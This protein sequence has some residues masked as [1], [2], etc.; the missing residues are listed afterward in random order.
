MPRIARVAIWATAFLAAAGAGAYIAAHSNPFPPG[1]EDPG[2]R[3]VSPSSV[4]PSPAAPDRWV[5]RLRSST[6]HQLY[7]GGRCATRWRGRV[8]LTVDRTEVIGAGNIRLLGQLACDF[9]VAQVQ[10]DHVVLGIEGR[11]H[12]DRIVLIL[13][14]RSVEPFASSQDYGGFLQ[15]L[16]TR[17]ALPVRGGRAAVHVTRRSV[18]EQG[19]GTYV[20]STGLRLERVSG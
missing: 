15:E 11:I 20:W 1:V 5:G 6:Y 9:P 10:I 18:D 2:A 19:R 14:V 8:H 4:S 13:R 17:L 7:V 16:P 12:G 3:S